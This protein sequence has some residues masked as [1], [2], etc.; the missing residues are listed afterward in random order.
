MS[1]LLLWRTFLYLL[2][3]LR[4]ACIVVCIYVFRYAF[5][6]SVSTLR[7]IGRIGGSDGGHADSLGE[8]DIGLYIKF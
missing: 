3:L 4:S 8:G 7:M 6:T 2:G 5:G 1:S